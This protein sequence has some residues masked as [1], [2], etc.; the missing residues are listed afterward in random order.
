MKENM[1]DVLMYLFEHYYMDEETELTFP[2]PVA[3]FAD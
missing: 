2:D 3:Y 1:F